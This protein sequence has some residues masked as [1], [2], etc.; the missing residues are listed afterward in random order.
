[1]LF[2][3][4]DIGDTRAIEPLLIALERDPENYAV[5]RALGNF[6]DRRVMTLL[7]SLLEP[8]G[9]EY[10]RF[11]IIS[12]LGHFNDPLVMESLKA[13]LKTG[14]SPYHRMIQAVQAQ[15]VLPTSPEKG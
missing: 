4:G 3:S 14:N 1:M 9:A 13:Y 6:P 15:F 10:W 5:T 2:R 11:E 7:L 8:E 12:T